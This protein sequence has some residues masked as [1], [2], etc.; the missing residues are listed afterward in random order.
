MRLAIYDFAIDRPLGDARR[1]K[2]ATQNDTPKG[3]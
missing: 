1:C 2:M 3:V